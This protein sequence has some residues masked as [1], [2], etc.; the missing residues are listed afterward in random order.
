MNL[1][2]LGGTRF[3]GRHI[4]DV[5]LA[6]GDEVTVFTRGR[7]ANPWGTAVTM[8]TG[9]RDPE[10]APGLAV[11][12]RGSWDAVIDTSGYVPRVVRASARLLAPRVRRYL[13]VSSISVLADA[14]RPGQDESA[15]VG[16]LREPATEEIGKYYGPLKAAC[17][18]VVSEVFGERALVVRPGLI[19][20]PFDPTD[21]F[22]YWIARFVHPHLLGAR[23]AEAVVPLP[24]ERRLQF[25]DAR[26]LALF[27][28]DALAQQASGTFN[29]TS[30]AGQWTFGELV[31]ALVAAGGPQ[32]PRPAWTDEAT[33]LAYKVTPWTGLPLWIPAVFTEEAGFMEIDCSKARRAGLPTRALVATVAD[34]AAWL[35]GRDNGTAWK[36]V[37]SADAEREILAAA[38]SGPSAIETNS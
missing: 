6:R 18:S 36:E 37:L 30:P 2:I 32:A 28:L 19:V 13:F 8:L 24:Q 15:P 22:G 27:M 7:Q 29:A 5:A 1:L 4:V 9:N 14:T 16:T 35:A 26:D 17:E 20:G 12:E 25:I 38:S 21:R 10:V 3:L 11:L 31:A 23:A 34:T 33:L